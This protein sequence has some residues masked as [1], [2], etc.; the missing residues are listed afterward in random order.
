MPLCE[1]RQ[2]AK[3]IAS[4]LQLVIGILGGSDKKLQLIM[5]TE[6]KI[7][8]YGISLLRSCIVSKSHPLCRLFPRY[9]LNNGSWSLLHSL[10]Q[11]TF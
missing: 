9:H 1:A 8:H 7:F 3:L 4:V 2:Y 5:S 10:D 11:Y 6:F